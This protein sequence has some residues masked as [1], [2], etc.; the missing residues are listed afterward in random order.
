MYI[1]LSIINTQPSL[2]PLPP[3][4]NN[5]AETFIASTNGNATHMTLYL[6]E[7]ANLHETP[8]TL[9]DIF[10]NGL[11]PTSIPNGLPNGLGTNMQL[12]NVLGPLDG[13][14]LPTTTPTGGDCGDNASPDNTIMVLMIVMMK[15]LHV[16]WI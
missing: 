1:Q 6:D 12:P 4:N 10:P 7:S 2:P 15:K 3:N 9:P 16:L 13:L 11:P 8:L 14:P 5:I